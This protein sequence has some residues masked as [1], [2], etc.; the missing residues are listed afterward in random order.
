LILET[1]NPACWTAFFDVYLR[2]PT[3]QRPLHP[4]TLKYL[5][6]ATGFQAV[7]VRFRHP[8]RDADR[9]GRVPLDDKHQSGDALT[10]VAAVLNAH[11]DALNSRL[12]SF[13]DY[14]VIARK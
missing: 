14:A 5:V 9:L 7:D 13:T 8:V 1:I 10:G 12:F 4:D 3:H 11:A 2:D 6:E